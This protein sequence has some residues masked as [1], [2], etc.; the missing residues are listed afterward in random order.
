MSKEVQMTFWVD[1]ELH[2]E[3]ADAALMEHQHETHVLREFMR[4][5]ANQSRERA[6]L[7]TAYA[8]TPAE[9]GRREAAV[10]FAR[11]SVGLEGFTPS[12]PAEIHAQQFIKG[13][14][15][16]AEFVQVPYDAEGA[17]NR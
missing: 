8:I 2:A 3:F 16:L 13:D 15:Q 1:A 12:K 5:Y 4:A 9:R 14:I 6:H 11:A 17:S 10:K 7:A